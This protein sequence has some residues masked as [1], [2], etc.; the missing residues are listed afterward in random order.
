MGVIIGVASVGDISVSGP[1]FDGQSKP[2]FELVDNG[3]DWSGGFAVG[4]LCGCLSVL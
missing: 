1:V 4:P 2:Q 3:Q